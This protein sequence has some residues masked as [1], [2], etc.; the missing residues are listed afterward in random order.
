ME[1][2]KNTQTASQPEKAKKETKKE[3]KQSNFWAEHKAELRKVTWPNRE[4]LLKETVTVII[5]SL[6]VGVIIYG[7]D[8]L[9]SF[10]YE[11]FVSIGSKTTTSTDAGAGTFD[12]SDLINVQTGEDADTSAEAVEENANAAET[13]DGENAEPAQAEG[14]ENAEPAQAGEEAAQNNAQEPVE[15]APAA[16]Q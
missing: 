1:E 2:T 6:L 10:G 9:L 3:K 12:A 13:P 5:V 15:A 8:T 16:E 7:M 14:A 11:K 4:E